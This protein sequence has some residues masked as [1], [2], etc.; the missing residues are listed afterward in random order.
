[1]NIYKKITPSIICLFLLGFY[2]IFYVGNALSPSSYGVFLEQAGAKSEGLFWGKPR[3]I[4]SDE[5]SVYTPMIQTAVNNNFERYNKTSP[6]KEDLRSG[7]ALPIKD[8]SIPFKPTLIGFTFLPPAYAFSLYNFSIIALFLTGFGVFFQRIGASSVIAIGI[9]LLLYFSSFIQNWWSTTG[10]L[11]ACFAWMYVV[12]TSDKKLAIRAV[13]FYYI[14]SCMFFSWF[15]P[16]F[17]YTFAFAILVFLLSFHRKFIT[18]KN[19]ITFGFCSI[20]A[21]LTYLFYIKDSLEALSNTIYPSQRSVSGGG[22]GL[23][24]WISQ[25]FPSL[26]IST[27]IA[28]TLNFES[29]VCEMATVGSY[30][31]LLILVFGQWKDYRK[32]ISS[33]DLRSLKFL[34]TGFLLIS[35]WMILPIPKSLAKIIFLDKVPGVRWFFASGIILMGIVTIFLKK[36]NFILTS[37]RLTIFI[38]CSISSV[39]FSTLYYKILNKDLVEESIIM[40][41]LLAITAQINQEIFKVNQKYFPYCLLILAL[42]VNVK[43]FIAFNPLQSAKPIFSIPQTNFVKSLWDKKNFNQDGFYVGTDLVGAIANG[44]GLPSIPHVLYVPQLKFFRC[45][46][47]EL[48]EEEFNLIFNRYL[49]VNISSQVSKPFNIQSDLSVIPLEKFTSNKN[50]N[51]SMLSCI[52]ASRACL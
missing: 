10:F 7:F 33:E 50:S 48:N 40:I 16:I 51:Q 36:M 6:Y 23:M 38:F 31:F 46:F 13:L 43:T 37:K 29:N 52:E 35:A 17:F 3:P 45:Y 8:W 24:Q 26:N 34:L 47:P 32:N 11:A 1:M 44:L 12:I 5:W 30:L 21:L 39:I 19:L 4:R 22:V 25:F 2:G 20:L 42:I 14:A 9:S 18:L 27:S 41:I 28:T 15:Y 49:H